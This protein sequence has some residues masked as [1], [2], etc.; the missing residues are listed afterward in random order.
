MYN[1]LMLLSTV[2]VCAL[3]PLAHADLVE[4][5]I[6]A[7]GIE[8]GLCVVIGIGDADLDANIAKRKSFVVE[9]LLTDWTAVHAHREALAKADVFPLANAQYVRNYEVLP[10]AP[11]LVNLLIIDMDA[12]KEAAPTEKEIKRA[13]VW[14]GKAYVKRGGTWSVLENPYPDDVDDWPHSLRGADRIPVSEDKRINDNIDGM[15]WSADN[16]KSV[17]QR[18]S[19]MLISDGKHYSI[20]QSWSREARKRGEWPQSYTLVARDAQ[21]GLVLWTA[22]VAWMPSFSSRVLSQ[23][24]NSHWATGNNKVYIYTKVGGHLQALDGDTGKVIHTYEQLPTLKPGNA[25]MPEAAN[26][27][28]KL[29]GLSHP[30]LR[31]TKFSEGRTP[32]A[33]PVHYAQ[34]SVL[35]LGDKLVHCFGNNVWIIEEASGKILGSGKVDAVIEQS[36]IGED[37]HLYCVGEGF[38]FSLELPSCKLRWKT[39]FSQ[40][41]A[42]VHQVKAFTGPKYGV[43][44]LLAVTEAEGSFSRGD[45]VGIDSSNGKEMWR[46][47]NQDFNATH[48]AMHRGMVMTDG[49]KNGTYYDPKTGKEV[50]GHRVDFDTGGCSYAT[51]TADYMIR[52]LALHSLANPENILI[53]DGVRGLCQNPVYPAYGQLYSFGTNCGCS[54]FYRAGLSA[55]YHAEDLTPTPDRERLFTEVGYDAP[56]QML[57]GTIVKSALTKDWSQGEGFYEGAKGFNLKAIPRPTLRAM[58]PFFR[59]A[60]RK[61]ARNKPANWYNDGTRVAEKDQ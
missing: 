61:W 49:W 28:T 38:A 39:Y 8:R 37:G 26:D 23:N 11:Q 17:E 33:Q 60:D 4:D 20:R 58:Q 52:G 57:K 53:G 5:A 16:H 35:V 25:A 13:L 21:N 15:K 24:Y 54:V 45:I 46:V 41:D 27:R 42:V 34:S 50:G 56:K 3:S 47:E 59:A 29:A 19:A 36:L 31:W 32:L 48:L 44:A 51:Y 55:F 30:A 18:G 2:I 1:L 43:L 10:Y 9:R 14:G 22:P 7:T 40:K 12:L 6:K